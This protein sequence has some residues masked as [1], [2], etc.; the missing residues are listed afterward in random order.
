[1]N[2]S[3]IDI[4][5]VTYC[6]TTAAHLPIDRII[7]I[8]NIAISFKAANSGLIKYEFQF[9]DWF[10]A[11]STGA[12]CRVAVAFGLAL[13]WGDA[14]LAFI[15]GGQ[16]CVATSPKLWHCLCLAILYPCLYLVRSS[17]CCAGEIRRLCQYSCSIPTLV[18]E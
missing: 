13:L 11:L 1:M 17:L 14:C 5:K 16:V 6:Y 9:M 8:Y 10:I 2:I 12:N 4:H 3:I 15:F 18:G 7:Y